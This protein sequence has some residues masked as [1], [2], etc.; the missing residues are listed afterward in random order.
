VTSLEET[1]PIYEP[2]RFMV[3]ALAVTAGPFAGRI[4][5]N[6]DDAFVLRSE[7]TEFEVEWMEEAG[8]DWRTPNLTEEEAPL[9]DPYRSE[10]GVDCEIVK[11]GKFMYCRGYYHIPQQF[12][13]PATIKDLIQRHREIQQEIFDAAWT[14]DTDEF[15]DGEL[16]NLLLEQSF[17]ADE[18]WAREMRLAT[19]HG[20]KNV[21]LC[22]ASADKPFVRQVCNDLA[23]AGHK[24]W[25]D[26]FEIAVGDSIVEKINEATN[27]ADALVLFVSASAVSS[28]WVK[29][30]WQSAL[31][32]QLSG[33]PIRILPAVIE[34]CQH[35]SLLS[36]IKYADFRSSY[37][38]G[39]EGLLD[40][41][42][43]KS[44]PSKEDN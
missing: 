41:L 5:E 26:E 11:F 8:V 2:P 44:G 22:H 31:A 42:A 27:N 37:Q 21:F 38:A 16:K 17:V 20:D 33:T 34:E 7:M 18:I 6:D 32:R 9:D 28:D 13:R 23:E 19:R 25:M 36:D 14:V 40:A 10:L 30:E 15:D 12:L 29:R 39:L 1:L 3:Q 35:P 4:C 24:V 43:N